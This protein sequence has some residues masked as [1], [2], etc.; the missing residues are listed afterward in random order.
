MLQ[1]TNQQI[2]ALRQN[3][4]S[5]AAAA[6]ALKELNSLYDEVRDKPVAASDYLVK[7]QTRQVSPPATSRTATVEPAAETV[8]GDRVPGGTTLATDRKAHM[9][10]RLGDARDRLRYINEALKKLIAI[11]AAE[12]A[13]IEKLTA[14]ISTRYEEAQDR[15][16]DVVLDLLG[17]VS[18]DA[19]AAKIALKT[20]PQN[21]AS[22]RAIEEE[23]IL[24]QSAKFRSEEAYAATAHL[25][26]G[27][28]MSKYGK[29]VDDWRRE[30]EDDWER[31]KSGLAL[32]ANLFL[33]HP[34][35]ERWLGKKA[36]FAGE[37]LWQVATMGRM[38]Y[39]AAGFAY[40]ILAQWAVWE[41]MT[42]RMQNDLKYN[43]QAIER[44]RQRA[45]QTSKEIGCLENLLR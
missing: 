4:A 15:A 42:H 22:L 32:A 20:T 1:R 34:A 5:A 3:P 25:V 8:C 29:D 45:E 10:K 9:S 26:D 24:L 16:W 44:L 7:L 6:G 19:I 43:V 35:L 2:A 37:K 33:D 17:G 36:F 21:A 28:K 27:L 14:E 18:L 41:Q 13:E 11:N 39:Y 38:A 23:I 31:A 30:N 12:R 40:D